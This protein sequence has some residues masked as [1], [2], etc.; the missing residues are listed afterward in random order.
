MTDARSKLDILY[1][2][3][4]GDV[5]DLVER[6]EVLKSDMPAAFDEAAGKLQG[7][8]A[9]LLSATRLIAQKITEQT[10]LIDSHAKEA[11]GLAAEAVKL[12]VRASVKESM[13]Q[14]AQEVLTTEILEAKGKVT[15]EIARLEAVTTNAVNRI[16]QAQELLRQ[17]RMANLF[18][19]GAASFFGYGLFFIFQKLVLH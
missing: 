6:V 17:E 12:D 18:I 4:L 3:V 2:D 19:C 15:A 14:I 10:A 11:A 8:A 1:Q 13:Q 7:E 9:N 16:Q 5:G